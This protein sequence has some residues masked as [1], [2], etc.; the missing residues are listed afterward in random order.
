MN[1]L[2]LGDPQFTKKMMKVY[3]WVMPVIFG[4]MFVLLT[5]TKAWIPASLFFVNELIVFPPLDKILWEKLN[6][7]IGL[8]F[9]ICAVLTVIALAFT[10]AYV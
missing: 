8:K 10:G 5:I 6:L 1:N 3:A 7:T 9:L 2:F 4:G